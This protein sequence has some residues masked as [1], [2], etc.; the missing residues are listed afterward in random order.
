[1]SAAIPTSAHT[2]EDHARARA[3]LLTSDSIGAVVMSSWVRSAS[4]P[5]PREH[6]KPCQV[7][8]APCG[9]LCRLASV[10]EIVTRTLAADHITPVQAYASLRAQSKEHS[11]FLLESVVPGE[12]WGRYSILG[13]RASSEQIYPSGRDA[14]ALLAPDVA[15]LPDADGLAARFTRA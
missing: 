10:T 9:V 12:R 7:P 2:S 1:K 3:S 15:G 13:Y 5:S 11:S 14:L 6:R 8:P 4:M